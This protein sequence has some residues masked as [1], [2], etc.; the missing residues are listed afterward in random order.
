MTA[1]SI[2]AA[3]TLARDLSGLRLSRRRVR[4]AI[5][6]GSLPARDLGGSVGFVTTDDA[7][8]QWVASLS[9]PTTTTTKD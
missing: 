6:D 3:H 7:V 2:T 9:V 4:L 1:L 8:R 5:A